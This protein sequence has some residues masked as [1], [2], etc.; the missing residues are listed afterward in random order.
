MKGAL[1][2]SLVRYDVKSLSVEHD[3]M[4]TVIEQAMPEIVRATSFF[5]KT[6]SQFMDNIMTVSHASDM[7]N[8]YQILAEVTNSR[9]AL[10]EA[11]LG[12]KK[13]AIE[14]KMKQREFD[15]CDDD[16]KRELLQVEIDE[17]KT[18]LNTSE[19]YISGAIRKVSNYMEQYKRIIEKLK[20]EKG[21]NEFNELD[22][23][24]LEEEHHIKKAFEQAITAARAHGGVIDEGNH[25]Y[26]SNLGISGAMAQAEVSGLLMLEKHLIDEAVKKQDMSLVPTYDIVWNFL[27][28]MSKK[29]KGTATVMAEKRGMTIKTESAALKIGD[30]RLLEN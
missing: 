2:N 12:N 11:I 28:Q 13:K 10:S 5:G 7:R 3:D 27:D 29:Y 15:S 17:I 25:I 21:I 23:E 18:Q 24:E 1:V 14:I 26:F 6:Q 19:I 30:R 22:F 9:Q 16:L 8:I 20:K 4:L